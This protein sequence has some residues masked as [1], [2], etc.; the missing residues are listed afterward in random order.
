MAKVAFLGLGQ[1]GAP[2]AA[3]LLASGHDLVVWNRN[4]AKAESLVR[5]GAR[6]A[7][8]PQQ[9]AM[10]RDVAITMLADPAALADVVFG[11]AGLAGGLV[12][13]STLIDM[14]TVGPDAV[15]RTA[16]QL[17]NN[18][19]MLDAPVLGSVP[20]A[21][22]GNLAIFV[23]GSQSDYERLEE[24]LQAFGRPRRCGPLGAGAALKLAVNSTL[25]AAMTALGEALSLADAFG[26]DP[27]LVLDV[28]ADSPLG[29]TARAKRD[30][31]ESG[32]YP[33]R[34][35][36]ALA[37]KDLQLVTEAAAQRGVELSLASAAH[38]WFEAASAAGYGDLDYSAV[39]AR[40][41]DRP[42]RLS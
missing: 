40:I 25:G 9:A 31:I 33:P 6:L 16:A 5:Q 19:R 17:P 21:Q 27:H 12:S 29:V 8:S 18:V 41:R 20:Q 36:L 7:A 38:A 26:L 1:M 4:A 35:K 14:S 10:G 11:P 15:Q 23:G 13:G 34:F 39:I 24:V 3:R 28:L 37:V 2:M 32:A 42:A 22:E 30:H